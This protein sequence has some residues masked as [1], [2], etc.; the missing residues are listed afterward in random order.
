MKRNNKKKERKRKE[1]T[2]Q[3]G[4]RCIKNRASLFVFLSLSHLSQEPFF[5]SLLLCIEIVFV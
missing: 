4:A 5:S 2:N 1:K 3:T